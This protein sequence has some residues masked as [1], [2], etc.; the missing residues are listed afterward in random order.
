MDDLL[1]KY[2][3]YMRLENCKVQYELSNGMKIEAIYKE[4]NFAHFVKIV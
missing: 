3:D 1:K 2:N 4:E